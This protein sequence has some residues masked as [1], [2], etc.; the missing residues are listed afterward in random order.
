MN[1]YMPVT[2]YDEENCVINHANDM[3]QLGEKALIVTGKHSSKKNG[4]L[5]DVTNVLGLHNVSYRIFDEIEEN[6]SIETVMK[7]RN[8][9]ASEN[10][11]FVIGIGGGS[12]IDAAK[13]IALMLANLDTAEDFLDKKTQKAA[14]LDVVAVPTTCGTGSEVTGVS[15]LTRHSKRTKGSIAHKIYPTFA[16]ID[17]KYLKSAQ[18]SL[19]VNT[20][21]DAL[22][23]LIESYINTNACAYSK[24]FVHEGLRTWK[25]S[26]NA[27]LN[28][29]KETPDDC[30]DILSDDDYRN[31]MRAS[32][33]AGMAIAHTGTSI[34]H[35][36][37][38]PVTYELNIPHGKACA[39]FLAGY[40][41][42]APEDVQKILLNLAGFDSIGQFRD[43]LINI[44]NLQ[45]IPENIVN[46]SI[47][48]LV[49]NEAKLKNCPYK[50]DKS[51]LR[52]IADFTLE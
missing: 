11:G 24:M 25:A 35:G 50:I 47:N 49:S 44:C 40:L 16:L 26:K 37:S 8:I 28:L 10:I 39:Y 36:L 48:M 38:Y 2:V 29:V 3:A 51:V 32:T 41:K 18:T 43:F 33:F 17:S 52:K 42:E 5:S 45:V 15:V 1:F 31:L 30:S 20:S 12:C 23:H 46:S 4:A 13:A 21:A 19:I 7:A 27:L 22:A 14:C 9:F 34:P 6:P